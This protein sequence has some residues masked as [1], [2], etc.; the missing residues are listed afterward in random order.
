M[1]YKSLLKKLQKFSPEELEQ[2]V[3]LYYGD[4]GTYSK[5]IY[6]NKTKKENEN[7]GCPDVDPPSGW[8]KGQ[9]YLTH[10]C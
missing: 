4:G 10:Y 3:V 7:L 6:F 9:W 5:I 1:K 2:E 8:K